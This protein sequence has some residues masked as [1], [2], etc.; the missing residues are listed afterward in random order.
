MFSDI[1]KYAIAAIV[2]IATGLL[3]YS[4]SQIRSE[5]PD[6]DREY[7]DP[8]PLGLKVLWPLINIFAYHIG[9]YLSVEYLER[10]KRLLQRSELIYLMDPEQFFGLQI[11]ASLFF[12]LAAWVGY[13]MMD[14]DPGYVPL[15]V[16]AFG[17]IFPWITLSDRKK[18]REIQIVRAL[19]VYLDYLTMSVQSG[20]NLSGAMLQATDK[21]PSG[22]LRNEFMLV[23][24]EIRS[25]KSRV[26]AFQAMAERIDLKEINNFASAIAQAEKT[27]SSLGDILQIQADQRRIERFQ[28]AEKLA[29]E[30][31]VKLIFPLV[32][33]IFPTT[34]AILG[35]LIVMKYMYEI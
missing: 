10:Q 7:M 11:V 32:A 29:L 22:P 23:L 1:F 15:M 6:E 13:S 21:G 17:F 30:A 27:G 18:K 24:R 20:L 5:V 3:I 26:R 9:Q 14:T 25:G 2:A 33:F 28:K 35:F 8:V 12:G 4:I 19:P 31:P 34:F 16:A